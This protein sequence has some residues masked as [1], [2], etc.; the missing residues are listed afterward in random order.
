MVTPNQDEA[1]HGNDEL[2]FL[3]DVLH[4][5]WSCQL[6]IERLRQDLRDELG[7]AYAKGEGPIE[8]RKRFS[9]T[10]LDEHLLLVTA[11]NVFRALDQDK[12]LSKRLETNS[13]TRNAITYLRN[14]YE[15]WDDHDKGL[16]FG[17]FKE[18]F[19][20]ARPRSL[21]IKRD[22][23]MLAGVVSLRQFSDDLKALEAEI[24]GLEA[25]RGAS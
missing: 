16:S 23:L 10:S 5:I 15:H 4:W 20:E 12:K 14:I 21:T 3:D 6:Q 7:G 13:A 19:P 25:E 2:R 17:K 11:R 9:R 24:L 18:A 22:D 1:P 8:G